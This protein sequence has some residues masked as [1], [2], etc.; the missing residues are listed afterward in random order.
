MAS[1]INVIYKSG[2]EVSINNTPWP[3]GNIP[4]IRLNFEKYIKT[5]KQ[6]TFTFEFRDRKDNTVNSNIFLAVD[7]RDISS[8]TEYEL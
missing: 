1:K 6:E 3:G 5:G 7:F 8:I 4:N 2:V